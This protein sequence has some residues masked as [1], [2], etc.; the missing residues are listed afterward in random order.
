[1]ISM[2]MK[3]KLLSH[4]DFHL[5]RNNIEISDKK[6]TFGDQSLINLSDLGSCVNRDKVI[7]Y[8][9]D[10]KLSVANYVVFQKFNSFRWPLW[11]HQSLSPDSAVF[12]PITNLRMG[13]NSCRNWSVFSNLLSTDKVIVDQC[14]MISPTYDDWSI[15]FWLISDGNVLRPQDRISSQGSIAQSRDTASSIITTVWKEK[16][17]EM[18]SDVYGTRTSI[19][20][21]VSDIS[22]SNSKN[23]KDSYFFVVVRPYTVMKLSGV[24][25]AEYRE[26]TGSIRINGT[27]RVIAGNTPDIIVCGNGADGDLFYSSLGSSGNSVSCKYGMATIALGFKIR[28]EPRALHIRIGLDRKKGISPLS[29]NYSAVRKDFS[30]Y[31]NHRIHN[32]ITITVPDPLFQKWFYASK[33]LSL[34]SS[35]S[36]RI[37]KKTGSCNTAPARSR[38]FTITGYN[39]MGY[40]NESL[41]L[42]SQ[43]FKELPETEK[44]SFEDAIDLSYAILTVSDYFTISRD[45]EFLQSYFE[46]LK[47]QSGKLLDVIQRILGKKVD[48][49]KL[50]N[51]SLLFNFSNSMHLYD[52]ILI[53]Y[54]FREYSYLARCIG[55]FGEEIKYTK[56]AD[57]LDS[58]ISSHVKRACM[59]I[60]PLSSGKTPEGISNNVDNIEKDETDTFLSDICY[61]P[62]QCNEFIGYYLYS[63]YPFTI[64][65]LSKEDFS[66]LLDRI[67]NYYKSR[68]L[69]IPSAGGYD[70]I[71]SLIYAHNLLL[72]KDPGCI[73]ILDTILKM[74]GMTYSVPEFVNPATGSGVNGQGDPPHFSALLF[75]LLR[76][77]LFID[78]SNRLELFPLPREEWFVPGVEFNINDAP[79]RFGLLHIKVIN[80]QNEI[81]IHFP[82]LP[83]FVPPDIMINLP[84]KVSLKEEDD[85]VIKK[86]YGNS[87]II[88][89][90]PSII[91]FTRR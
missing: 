23:T 31:I 68:M 82:V 15:E 7:R 66:S 44:I 89:G 61:D 55:L 35:T 5:T 41:S 37:A 17:Y 86:R 59:K 90:W 67:S 38:Y 16:Y 46:T 8:S 47:K 51:N 91:R 72:Q 26:D 58:I 79:S 74:G 65:S 48:V 32:G 27:D 43:M 76:N 75:Q 34:N 28:K 80:T 62:S 57:I 50:K 69:Y 1:M 60:A 21:I 22:F 19:D 83:K 40:F 30:N 11:V 71:L 36:N 18:K 33:L 56:P 6:K 25:N 52:F 81:H 54:T 78:H 3:K 12:N 24:F 20:E 85:F 4:S 73:E 29:M 63:G 13:N 14:G 2:K 9:D 42:I 88:N 64:D 70:I 39:R 77:L 87:Y 10:M 49:N 45:L 84:V 53:A